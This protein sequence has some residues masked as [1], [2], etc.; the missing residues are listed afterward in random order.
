MEIFNNITN[1]MATTTAQKSAEI[2]RP[3]ADVSEP[4][5]AA[6]LNKQNSE[7]IKAKLDQAVN[8]LND[9]MQKM[10]TNLRFGYNEPLNTL[11]VSL[12]NAQ[13]GDTIRQYPSEQVIK[14]RENL[15]EQIRSLFKQQ[16]L[17]LDQT[18]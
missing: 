12:I 1:S 18:N 7:E 6:E 17:L 14:M 10:D 13:N 2:Q 15:Q 5:G 3:V 4:K 11:T 16:G 8:D 9:Y